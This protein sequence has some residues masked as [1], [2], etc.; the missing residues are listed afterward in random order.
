MVMV[1]VGV[2]VIVRVR[3]IVI[4]RV[5]VMVRVS[6]TK[7]LPAPPAP[8]IPPVSLPVAPAPP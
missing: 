8:N 3:V 6:S 2:M 5:R 7:H 4:V 1:R